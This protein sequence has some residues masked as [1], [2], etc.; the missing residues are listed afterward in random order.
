[1]TDLPAYLEAEFRRY[2]PD[3]ACPIVVTLHDDET[4][5][6]AIGGDDRGCDPD[7]TFIMNIGSDDDWF[8]FNDGTGLIITVPLM[9]EA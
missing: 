3:L 7:Y 2:F 1:M 5:E 4:I 6:I 8:V 9:P